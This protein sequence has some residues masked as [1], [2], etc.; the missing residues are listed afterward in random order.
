MERRLDR[1]R[2]VGATG[3]INRFSMPLSFSTP[4]FLFHTTG[5]ALDWATRYA[6]AGNR[7]E[8]REPTL[9][10]GSI[11]PSLSSDRCCSRSR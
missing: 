9:H 6:F 3:T 7:N 10:W 4:L 8:A 2:W 5:M 11:G 1:P